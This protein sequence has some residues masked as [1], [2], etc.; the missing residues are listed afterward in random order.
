M[1]RSLQTASRRQHTTFTRGGRSSVF[2][3]NSVL[4]FVPDSERY[5]GYT[6]F[7]HKVCED[8]LV[9]Y[10]DAFYQN[11]KTHNELAPGA[12]NSFQTTG[13]V[14]LAIPPN[15]PLAVGPGGGQ[16]TK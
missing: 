6:S 9:L 10:G 2:N 14:T 4:G 15:S 5:G 16:A 12:T 8:Q 7:T 11:V 1:R 13:Q 3:F